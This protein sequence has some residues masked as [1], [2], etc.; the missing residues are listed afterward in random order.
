M[1]YDRGPQKLPCP[2][3]C[4]GMMALVYLPPGQGEHSKHEMVWERTYRY[5]CDNKATCGYA[6][7]HADMLRR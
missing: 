7:D 1:A 5:E 2:C 6:E 3:Q 4:G